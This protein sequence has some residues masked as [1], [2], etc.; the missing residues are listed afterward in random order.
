MQQFSVEESTVKML[1]IGTPEKNAVIIL[2][3]EQY[4]L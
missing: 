4:R 2:Q 1:K 3:L